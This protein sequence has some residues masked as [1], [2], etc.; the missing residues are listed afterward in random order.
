MTFNRSAK[1]LAWLALAAAPLF[2]SSWALHA[3]TRSAATLQ[4]TV[5]TAT[6]TERPLADLVADVT[7]I[8]R[9]EIERSGATGLA[10]VLARV[11]GIEMARNGGPGTT[12][13]LF[14]RGAESQLTA[15]YVD[16]IRVDSQSASGG[17]TWENIPLAQIERIEVLRGPASA[18][19]GSD[20]MG[21]VIQVITRKGEGAWSPYVGL[22]L[23]TYGTQKTEAGFSGTSGALDYALGVADEVSNGFNA[24]PIA[25]RNPDDD[26]YRS[27]SARGRLGL[28]LNEAHRLEASVLSSDLVSRYDSTTLRRDDLNLRHLQA[29][30]L[31]WQAQWSAAYSTRLS[32]TSTEDKYETRPGT[33]LTRTD[34]QGYLFQN[35]YRQGD[36]LWTATLERR[37]DRLNNA[38]TTPRNTSRAQDGVALGYGWSAGPHSLQLHVRQ[39]QDSEFGTQNTGSAAYGYAF[40]P[41]W[42]FTA[43]TGTAFRAPTLYQRFSK[44][45]LST[46]QPQTS[47]NVEVGLRRTEGTS[48]WGVVAYRN[49]VS[50]L[51]DN[52]SGSGPCANGSSCYANVSEA[53]YTGITLSGSQQLGNTRWH[54]SLDVQDP[55]DRD[56]GK[57]LRRRANQHAVLGV[58]TLLGGWSLGTDAQLSGVR[59]SDAANTMV[60]PGYV[61]VSLHAQ[62]RVGKAWS[63]LLRVDNATDARYQLVSDYAT[64]GRT[65]F[66]GLRWAPQ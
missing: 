34:L 24:Q 5:V 60:L 45:G 42:R 53:E 57:L 43:S 35:D 9:A 37:E 55:R 48:S 29:A 26:G 64:P 11:P 50:N 10:D 19:Y 1:R 63:V 38:D 40:T 46:L 44:Y 7:V 12:T 52:V 59:F 22:G 58:S 23:G 15:V 8:D 13:S 21:G 36:H 33:Y 66:V 31:S 25:T 47:H 20:A 6:R 4:E 16:G 62:T 56:S 61:L 51:I 30:G 54:A 49:K 32:M 18:V 41:R 17:A 2:F 27:Q 65:L 39:D 3:Q 28:R 14:I